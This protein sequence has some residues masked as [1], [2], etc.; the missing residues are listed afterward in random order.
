MA[1]ELQRARAMSAARRAALLGGRLAAKLRN[2]VLYLIRKALGSLRDAV[3]LRLARLWLDRQRPPPSLLGRVPVRTTYLFA[4]HEYQPHR[5]L[6]GSDLVLFR[7]TQGVGL[8]T[9][10]IDFFVD[11]ALGWDRRGSGGVRIVDV[12]GG[13][14]SMLQEPNVAVLA[15]RLQEEMDRSLAHGERLPLSRSAGTA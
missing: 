2:F 13:H 5:Q 6:E 10:F 4:A 8:D 9:P 11:P 15:A 12:P 1:G 3:R 7:A 14:S